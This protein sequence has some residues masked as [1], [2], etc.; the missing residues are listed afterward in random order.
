MVDLNAK[1]KNLVEGLPEEIWEN[2]STKIDLYR[3]KNFSEEEI[4]EEINN[5]VKLEL[6]AY[7][8]TK[9]EYLG[10]YNQKF[11]QRKTF[12]FVKDILSR[13]PLLE[14]DFYTLAR[15]DI[16]MNG[17]KVLNDLSGDYSVGSESLRIVSDILQNGKTTNWLKERG[18][19]VFVSVE[20]GDEFGVLVYGEKDIRGISD[21]MM[22]RYFNEVRESD[23]SNLI[24]FNNPD[25]RER[26]ELLDLSEHIN[27]DFKFEISISIGIA[28][29][30]E[31]LN[32]TDLNKDV[33][34]AEN[35]RNIRRKLFD[36][37]HVRSLE[38]KRWYKQILH[39][40]NPVLS[41]LYARMN[42]DVIEL[43]RQIQ[44]LKE[45]IEKLEKGDSTQ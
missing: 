25:V 7:T 3:S 41:A 13:E 44:F 35:I 30:A 22:S 37:A 6:L 29:L 33:G 34:Q 24:D 31:A 8:E 4:L 5:L 19:E 39:E 42:K 38:N 27:D 23:V 32:F 14:K 36:I 18:Y 28:F 17:L 9:R 20:G 26:L 21:E 2:V 45:K 12:W 1:I 10:L 43:T 40:E 11:S 16:D 15:L